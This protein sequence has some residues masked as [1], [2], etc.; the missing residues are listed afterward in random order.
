MSM[1]DKPLSELEEKPILTLIQQ[2]KD[3]LV[4]P[5][6]IDKDLRQQAIEVLMAEGYAVASMAQVFKKCDKTIRRDLEEI[7]QRHELVPDAGLA[8]RI[9]GEMLVFAR[10]HRDHLMRLARTKDTSVS[11]KAQAEYLAAR[12]TME[13]VDKLQSLG[14]LP[15]QPKT[16]VGDIFHHLNGTDLESAIK[17]MSQQCA[18][19]EKM[20]L[21]N[22]NLPS[23]IQ[24]DLIEVKAVIKK[25]QALEPVKDGK[26]GK[27]EHETE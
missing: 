14:Y 22:D 6:S 27:D 3:G 12:V 16:V 11:E 1:P 26:R 4:A 8:K 13:L 17:E 25:A 23:E 15:N 18:E 2:I 19:V 5:D 7:R 24:K 10:G 9:I 21:G 20:V